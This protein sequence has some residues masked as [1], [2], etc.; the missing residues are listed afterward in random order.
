MSI[1]QQNKN[2]RMLSTKPK[3]C[4]DINSISYIMYIEAQPMLYFPFIFF[5]DLQIYFIVQINNY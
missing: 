5:L 4:R 2:S 1:H 3:A